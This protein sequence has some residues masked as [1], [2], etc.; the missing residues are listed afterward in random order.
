MR[1][2]LLLE[3]QKVLILLPNMCNYAMKDGMVR[4]MI[5]KKRDKLYNLWLDCK[6]VGTAYM[7][8]NRELISLV[9]T[10]GHYAV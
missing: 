8:S 4:T 5:Q 9:Y 7:T 1:S 6:V 3:K 10:G 2:K